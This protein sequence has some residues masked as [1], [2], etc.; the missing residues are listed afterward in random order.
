MASHQVVLVTGTSSGFGRLI[1]RT[2][3]RRGHTVFATMREPEIKNAAAA[4]DLRVLAGKERIPLHVLPMD[5]TSDASVSEAVGRAMEQEGRIDAIVHNAA[6]ASFGITEAFTLDQV[7]EQFETNV[8]GPLRVNRAALPHLRQA[9]RGFILHISASIARSPLPF[10]G[11]Y[12]ATKAALEVLAEEARYVLAPLGIDSAILQPGVYPT[13]LQQKL[14]QPLDGARASGY[15]PLFP[16]MEQMG[17]FMQYMLSTRPDPQEVADAV[18]RLVEAPPGTRPLRTLVGAAHPGGV[19]A[20]NDS[21]DR[22][23]EGFYGGMG[24]GHLV[25]RPGAER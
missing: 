19:E 11:V 5:V 3:A 12:C 24:I 13:P 9:A 4:V 15:G 16:V 23:I 2:L 6:I 18:L 14:L 20:L 17:K 1:S 8:F 25:H 10:M 22:L 21:S 7:K